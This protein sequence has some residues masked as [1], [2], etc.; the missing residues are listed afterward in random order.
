MNNIKDLAPNKRKALQLILLFGLVSLFGDIIYE[1]ARSVNGPYLKVL[2]ANAIAVGFIAG[3]GEFLGYGIRLLSGYFSDKTKAYWFFTILGYGMLVSVP[4]LALTGFWQIAALLIVMERIGKAMR[5]PAKDTIL[6]QATKQVGT[7]FGFGLNE[8]M[9]QIGAIIG[10]LLF[11]V[12]FMG[13]SHAEKGLR[14]YQSA[15][16]LLWLPF[17]F[18]M[19]C[20]LFAFWKTPNPETLETAVKKT[21]SEKLPKIFWLY[22]AFSF[23]ATM[24]FVNF[25]L[26]AYH[27]KSKAVLSDAQIPLFYA[28]AMG[29]D[30]AA[31]LVIGKVYDGMKEKQK[32]DWAGIGTLLMIPVLSIVIP[33]LCFTTV[34]WIAILSIAFW[35]IVMAGHETIMKSAIADITPLKKRGTGYGILNVAYGLAMLVGGVVMGFLYERSL[36]ALMISAAALELT[37]LPFFFAMK[38]EVSKNPA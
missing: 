4:L 16:H 36:P 7:G 3:L 14:D 26:M 35:G 28:I 1:G 38:R 21:E 24:G 12:A 18:L 11:T 17:F 34:P 13:T 29:I 5:S 33:F 22:T 8:A 19:A 30:G 32:H 10:P 23:L 2:G 37:S 31:A 27:F 15:Y 20:V 6:S 9:D 25:V